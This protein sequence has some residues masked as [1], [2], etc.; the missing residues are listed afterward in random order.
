MRKTRRVSKKRRGT[1]RRRYG[2]KAQRGGSTFCLKYLLLNYEHVKDL[3]PDKP[4][5]TP[6][7]AQ[8]DFKELWESLPR[9]EKD[10]L[11]AYYFR[12]KRF[13]FGVEITPESPE[14]G[15]HCIIYSQEHLDLLAQSAG[16]TRQELLNILKTRLVRIETYADKY[17]MDLIKIAFNSPEDEGPLQTERGQ[18]VKATYRSLIE[19]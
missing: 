1:I 18:I 19:Q 6:S 7:N 17:K 13:H 10:V 9:W 16:M 4:A 8:E 12:A 3:G 14:V 15:N 2:R 11:D 5:A